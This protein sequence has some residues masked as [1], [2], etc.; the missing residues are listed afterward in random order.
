VLERADKAILGCLREFLQMLI[1][2]QFNKTSSE[3]QTVVNQVPVHSC[4]LL[5]QCVLSK[6][7]LRPTGLVKSPRT[8]LLCFNKSFGPQMPLRGWKSG[9]IPM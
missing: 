3:W 9:S 5:L 4:G 2:G 1:P 7:H 6:H 8:S